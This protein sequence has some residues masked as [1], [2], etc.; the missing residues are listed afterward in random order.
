MSVVS[1]SVVYETTGQIFFFSFRVNA[2]EACCCYSRAST[3]HT[4][5]SLRA[6]A[7]V[8]SDVA[9]AAACFLRASC[10]VMKKFH[11]PTSM[12]MAWC[13]L[14]PPPATTL[15]YY[16]FDVL[17]LSITPLECCVLRRP[18]GAWPAFNIFIISSSTKRRETF[19]LSRRIYV[20]IR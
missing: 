19:F 8:V 16:I 18:S 12:M 1:R 11:Q 13:M 17:R 15:A 5:P 6:R 7:V 3:T 20:L 2:E 14:A 10:C 9:A 4:P